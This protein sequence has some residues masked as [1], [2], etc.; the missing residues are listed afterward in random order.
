MTRP[1]RRQPRILA[2]VLV[3]FVALLVAACGETNPSSPPATPAS[4][5]PSASP[6]SP[7]PSPTA[8]ASQAAGPC[9]GTDLRVTGG[10]WG[11]AAGS[12]GSDVLVENLGATP[13][14]LPAGPLVAL[15]DATGSVLQQSGPTPVGEGPAIGPGGSRTFSLVIGNWCDDSVAL[16]V[17]LQL[18]LA[19]G[20][21][22]IGGLVLAT[23]DELPPCNGPGQPATLSTTTWEFPPT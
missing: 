19:G 8:T 21:V 14:V 23:V 10:P 16:P 7:S 6:S 18:A 15:I 20:S 4:A 2:L 13:C 9:A 5:S 22:D 11:G 1:T 3:G 17:R 12:R